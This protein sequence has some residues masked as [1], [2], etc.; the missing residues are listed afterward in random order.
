MN[1]APC[2][3]IKQFCRLVVALL[4]LLSAVELVVA[5]GKYSTRSMADCTEPFCAV[6]PHAG[7]V[8]PHQ[9]LLGKP[10]HQRRRRCQSSD[11]GSLAAATCGG[12][13]KEL[14]PCHEALSGPGSS[15]GV[16]RP[17]LE[18]VTYLRLLGCACVLYNSCHVC[19][20]CLP[21]SS[22][23][24][25]KLAQEVPPVQRSTQSAWLFRQADSSGQQVGQRQPLSRIING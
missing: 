16:M 10:W 3:P 13:L 21:G 1:P 24:A 9:A 2:V 14:V 23:Q 19:A 20:L 17:M 22:R 25:R 12:L 5:A 6:L 18:C 7:S 4:C 11:S 15:T 8:I